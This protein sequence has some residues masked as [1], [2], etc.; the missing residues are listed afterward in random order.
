MPQ[1]IGSAWTGD[2]IK[3][4][5]VKAPTHA[6][7]IFIAQKGRD[8]MR[9]RFKTSGTRATVTTLPIIH[10]TVPQE[11]TLDVYG[12]WQHARDWFLSNARRAGHKPG[13]IETRRQR[14]TAF[15]E[16]CD[17]RCICPG[18]VT[19]QHFKEFVDHCLESGLSKFTINGRIR[20]LRTFYNE[21]IAEGIFQSN[22]AT[23]V[24]KL[25]EPTNA[26][27]PLSQEEVRA[28]LSVFNLRDWVELRD[29]II[30]VVILDTG[31]RVT[32]C[33]NAKVEHLNLK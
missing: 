1:N 17:A 33:L 23:G 21:G 25:T 11:N 15:A 19:A 14:F 32:E 24:K 16:W 6:G 30:T 5:P 4:F 3:P 12:N 31:I 10:T 2:L 18:E 20:V 26:V 28:L 22:P 27:I 9:G 29:F 13:S 7:A 8:N